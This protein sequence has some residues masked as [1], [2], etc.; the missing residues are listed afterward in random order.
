M[1]AHHEPAAVR[2]KKSSSGVVRIGVGV[3]VFV[4]LAMI[5]YPYTQLVLEK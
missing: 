5:A 1:F 3:G 4:V 2:E